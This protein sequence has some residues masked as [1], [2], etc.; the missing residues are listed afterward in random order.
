MSS[1]TPPS[2][3]FEPADVPDDGAGIDGAN[4]ETVGDAVDAPETADDAANGS[5]AA[6]D[7]DVVAVYASLRRSEEVVDAFVATARRRRAL[8]AEEI[9]VLARADALIGDVAADLS[10]RKHAREIARRSM[11]ADL[12]TA[13]RLSEWTV[14]RLLGQAADLCDRF[15]PVVDALERAE[16]SRQRVFTIYEAGAAIED[17]AARAAYV[18]LALAVAAELT[19]GRMRPVV[20]R[21]AERFLDRS[22]AERTADAHERRCVEVTDLDDGLS[23]LLAILPTTLAH[24]IDDRLTAQARTIVD[25]RPDQTATAETS[26][27]RGLGSADRASEG[28]AS[29]TASDAGVDT[30][31]LAQVRADV[32]TDLLL[33]G[34]PDECLGGD[35]LGEIRATVQ[36]T[37]P[38]LTMTG[39][40]SE[41][42][43]LAGYGPIDADT[44]QELAAGATGWDRV[45]TSPLDGGVLA[46][47][48][49]RPTAD[50]RRFLRA[51]DEHC[52]FPGCRRPVWRC[53]IDHTLDAAHGGP[54]CHTNTAHLCRRHH[55]LKHASAWTVAQTSPGVL[56]WTSPT[57]R[58][59]T[60]RPEPQVRFIPDPDLLPRRRRLEDYALLGGDR[61]GGASPPF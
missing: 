47:D 46:V 41:P 54:T 25:A 24:G 44:A 40:S 57:G 4:A 19:P 15:A 58:R 45:M 53:D 17:E 30:R 38:V 10:G 48:R 13:A 51:R 42:C 34:T 16:I 50:L 23:Q 20:R 11:V 27:A 2:G 26:A 52:R 55:T 49:Y 5:E 56:V 43:L 35:G 18:T 61:G 8:D 22:L 39:H 7:A 33:T 28:V 12:A 59:H 60:D 37:I 21:F 3:P 36:V 31:T 14:T 32:F 1:P 6:D 29:D 9:R